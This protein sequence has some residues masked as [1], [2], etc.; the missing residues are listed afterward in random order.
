MKLRYNDKYI[1]LNECKT[2]FN[3]LRGFMF[4]K[5]IDKALLFENCNSIHTFFMFNS[6]DVILCDNDNKVLYY[7]KDFKRNRIILPK[8]NVVKV[9]ETPA[10]Y[11]D[12]KV[13][14][15]VEVIK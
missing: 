10:S 7:Y 2:F 14:E 8:R 15:Y 9:Y 6:I 3:R 12:I 5:T 13:N 1:E 4:T 11:F